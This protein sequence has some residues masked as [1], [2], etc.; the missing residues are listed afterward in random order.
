MEADRRQKMWLECF[1]KKSVDLLDSERLSYGIGYIER[2]IPF[3]VTIDRTAEYCPFAIQRNST[4]VLRM[5][6]LIHWYSFGCFETLSPEK[7]FSKITN[8]I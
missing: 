3:F 8:T 6:F 1:A 4:A 2:K 5:R 7:D